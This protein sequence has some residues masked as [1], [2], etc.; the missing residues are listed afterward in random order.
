MMRAFTSIALRSTTGGPAPRFGQKSVGR[1]RED[2][3]AGN[4]TVP[5]VRLNFLEFCGRQFML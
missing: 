2:D 1:G 4:W 3:F 5:A